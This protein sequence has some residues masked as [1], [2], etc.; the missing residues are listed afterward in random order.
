MIDKVRTRA[1]K[2]ASQLNLGRTMVAIQDGCSV[3]KAAETAF[4]EYLDRH[5]NCPCCKGSG[6]RASEIYKLIASAMTETEP[7]SSEK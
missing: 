7:D 2:L 4:K 5:Q 1:A 6:L 3:E